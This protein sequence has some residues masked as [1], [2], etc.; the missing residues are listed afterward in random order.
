MCLASFCWHTED[1]YFGAVNYHHW[2]LPKIWYI[3]SP[4]NASKVENVLKNYL[5]SE[6]EEFAVYSLKVQVPPD[7]L[8]SN[9]IPVYRIVQ[10]ENEFV[11]AWPRAF[12]SGLN[13][14]FNCNEACNLA[15]VS[16]LQ[17]G[18]KSVTSYRFNRKTCLSFFSLLMR[19]VCCYK[20]FS[21]NDLSEVI[22]LFSFMV[23]QE[24][25]VRKNASYPSIQMY[26]HDD[27]DGCL[28]L[29]PLFTDASG[30]DFDPTLFLRLMALVYSRKEK[31]FLEG[32]K[33]LCSIP[34]KDCDLC[35][36]PTFGSCLVCSHCNCTVCVTCSSYHPCN[37]DTRVVLYRY[38]LEVLTR[39]MNI[40]K[41]FYYKLTG[42]AW[43]MKLDWTIPSNVDV[44]AIDN[45]S[46][47][48]GDELLNLNHFG[49]P[50]LQYRE[51]LLST[52]TEKEKGTGQLLQNLESI[53]T[54]AD[55]FRQE[56]SSSEMLLLGDAWDPN[57][58]NDIKEAVSRSRETETKRE[59]QE[60]LSIYGEIAFN[61][62][63]RIHSEKQT[64]NTDNRSLAVVSKFTARY[65]LLALEE[66][67]NESV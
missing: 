30:S 25:N 53:S 11:F 59:N 44:M 54:A 49:T 41:R 63:F 6:S 20:D 38:P 3:A 37:C 16:W 64:P 7:V 43:K 26:I 2:G 39:L 52:V 57:W 56:S 62:P 34:M 42:Q 23:S 24:Y 1:N 32:C 5:A 35:D 29:G 8:I 60:N 58:F 10:R 51:H 47:F 55:S 9:G 15:P 40:M 21:S 22:K 61:E 50:T 46:V 36:T 4:G 18:L 66:D 33:L 13:V 14:G 12:H 19:S 45:L 65:V 48:K 27:T 31:D 67:R 28:D 17:M